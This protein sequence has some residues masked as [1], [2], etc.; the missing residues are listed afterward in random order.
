MK[1]VQ[2]IEY[3]VTVIASGSDF[4]IFRN[5][6]PGRRL[7]RCLS[8]SVVLLGGGIRIRSYRLLVSEMCV[9]KLGCFL[10]VSQDGFIRNV[11]TEQ[12]GEVLLGVY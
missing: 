12:M 11:I 1:I 8:G 4:R 6:G 2:R 3:F 7:L 5:N 10:Q 9:E